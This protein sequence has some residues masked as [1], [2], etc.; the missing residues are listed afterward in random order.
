MLLANPSSARPLSRRLLAL[1]SAFGRLR[2]SSK[3]LPAALHHGSSFF[4][5]P[6][7][8]SL[9]GASSPPAKATHREPHYG[10]PRLTNGPPEGASSSS[11]RRP[12][13]PSFTSV[14]CRGTRP[15]SRAVTRQASAPPGP[16][17]KAELNAIASISRRCP[18]VCKY[19]ARPNAFL[20]CIR[21]QRQRMP[22]LGQSRILV[23]TSAV[24]GSHIHGR[25][26]RHVR[27]PSCLTPELA[28]PPRR[29]GPCEC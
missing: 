24:S 9:A 6:F 16:K 25:V 10:S 4:G 5:H 3:P 1:M 11:A 18:A 14:F 12:N 20:A 21:R 22:Y 27:C 23:L 19:K 15:L 13:P 8:P 2:V 29:V 7:P 26:S 28:S 17:P